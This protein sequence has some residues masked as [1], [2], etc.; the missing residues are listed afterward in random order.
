MKSINFF[1]SCFIILLFCG[2][3]KAKNY[4]GIVLDKHT[5]KPIPGVYI[6]INKIPVSYTNIEGQFTLSGNF[7]TRTKLSFS[8]LLYM[9]KTIPLSRFT[10]KALRI[11]LKEQQNNLNEVTVS[12]IEL[13]NILKKA[14]KNFKKNYS[15]F[16]YWTPS[17]LVQTMNYNG[18]YTS[19]TEATG[20]T[21]LTPIMYK[22]WWHNSP[23]TIPRKARRAYSDDFVESSS[24]NYSGP[25]KFLHR[26][27]IGSERYLN[28]HVA[29]FNRIHPLGRFNFRDYIFSLDSSPDSLQYFIRFKTK[30]KGF[31]ASE[32]H[33]G[34]SEG[35]F[36][37][38]K[39]DFSIKKICAVFNYGRR[40]QQVEI[41][42]DYVSKEKNV[43]PENI[44]V[45][46]VLFSKDRQDKVITSLELNFHDLDNIYLSDNL[47]KKNFYWGY[48]NWLFYEKLEFNPSDWKNT[49]NKD[50]SASSILKQMGKIDINR[51]FKTGDQL[52][53][54]LK[55]MK[56]YRFFKRL[57][58]KQ[59]KEAEKALNSALKTGNKSDRS[60]K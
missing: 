18:N 45:S 17:H 43:L 39:S 23:M 56:G 6:L 22:I 37:L 54:L 47:T 26:M 40:K 13:K 25:N 41:K 44:S 16:H 29:C 15:P 11:K 2:T 4:S 19:Y 12:A 32:W 34:F 58:P 35:W 7:D 53:M 10:D 8:H 51:A 5:K 1:L 20:Y 57:I 3:L 50:A 21:Y 46:Q 42:I 28:Y 30:P 48:R 9:E 52:P 36:K 49:S 38:D 27:Y 33:F 31:N 14:H 55:H 59:D 60:K 24:K